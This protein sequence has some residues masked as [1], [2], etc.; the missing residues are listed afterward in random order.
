MDE[1]EGEGE[2]VEGEEARGVSGVGGRDGRQED[3][4]GHA[5]GAGREGGR[6]GEREGGREGNSEGVKRH[7][8]RPLFMSPSPIRIEKK[9]LRRSNTERER[10]GGKKRERGGME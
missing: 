4:L 7:K 8:N 3:P 5:W 9:G 1:D 2:G 10:E 6:E